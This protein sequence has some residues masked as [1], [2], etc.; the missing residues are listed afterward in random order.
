[1]PV[2]TRTS[3]PPRESTSLEE[4]KSS[5]KTNFEED[6]LDVPAFIRK[7]AEGS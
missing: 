1:M 3:S 2:A 4:V 6:D 5:V 7:R